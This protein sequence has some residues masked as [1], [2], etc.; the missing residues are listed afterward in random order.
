MPLSE[1]EQRIL[2][3]IERSFYENDPA[4]AR[5]VDG[6]S[7]YRHARRKSKLAAA[8]FLMSLAVLL[9][10][11]ASFPIVAF[12]GFI[13]MVLSTAVFLHNTRRIG[14]SGLRDLAESERGIMVGNSV[15]GVK[16]GVRKRL[17]RHE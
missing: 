14:S 5:A 1:D 3:D 12:G 9:F 8:C 13:G 2:Q 4:F 11:F 16:E 10:T 7:F 17:R 6:K 15:R